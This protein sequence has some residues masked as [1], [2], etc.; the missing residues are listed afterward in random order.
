MYV[1]GRDVELLVFERLDVFR[2][3]LRRQLDLGVVEPLAHPRLTQAVADL[4]HPAG[5]V[6]R[7]GF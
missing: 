5:I 6:E 7:R 4:E 3:E 2:A 1:P